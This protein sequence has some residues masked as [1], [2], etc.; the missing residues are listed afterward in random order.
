M[1]ANNTIL[2]LRLCYSKRLI[3]LVLNVQGH[4]CFAN[5]QWTRWWIYHH[6][7]QQYTM[8]KR[9]AC[10]IANKINKEEQTEYGIV[11]F[12]SKANIDDFTLKNGKIEK[13]DM[14]VTEPAHN[15]ADTGTEESDW[16]II[17]KNSG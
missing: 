14:V 7:P 17:D 4:E 3:W 1:S 15:N 6:C 2:I 12:N 8:N 16:I 13:C 11:Q 10:H 9:L 5:A